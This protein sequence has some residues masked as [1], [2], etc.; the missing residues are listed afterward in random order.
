MG[1]RKGM[2][3]AVEPMVNLGTFET[4]VKEDK[5]TVVTK[6]GALS[7]HWEHSSAITDGEPLILTL[8]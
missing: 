6:D 2:C 3:L 4:V 8:P 5:W 7:C 1:L